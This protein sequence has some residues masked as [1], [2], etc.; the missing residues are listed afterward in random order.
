MSIKFEISSTSKLNLE[1]SSNQ[2]Q[3]TTKARRCQSRYATKA[4]L[5]FKRRA[6]D[7][8]I[9]FEKSGYHEKASS[10]SGRQKEV[11]SE[12]PK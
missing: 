8:L 4:R 5:G 3:S 7:E 10:Q 12:L 6:S 1:L 11:V 9:K 2:M